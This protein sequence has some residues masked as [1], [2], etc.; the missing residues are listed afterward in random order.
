MEE[1]QSQPE[2][3]QILEEHVGLLAPP[4]RTYCALAVGAMDPLGSALKHFREDFERHIREGWCPWK[5]NGRA[6]E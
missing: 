4:G 3:L 2:D 5:K 1:G 6:R